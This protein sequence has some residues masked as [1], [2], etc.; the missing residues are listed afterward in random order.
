[1]A[2]RQELLG[3][4]EL[5]GLSSSSMDRIELRPAKKFRYVYRRRANQ[6]LLSQLEL[7]KTVLAGNISNKP[8]L[9]K[10][11]SNKPAH[12]THVLAHGVALLHK[13]KRL[14]R[15]LSV[16]SLLMHRRLYTPPFIR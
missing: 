4:R 16:L 6:L 10:N 12:K 8:Q 2:F 11:I 3:W 9:K 5:F 14:K 1:M 13:I 15:L 7:I